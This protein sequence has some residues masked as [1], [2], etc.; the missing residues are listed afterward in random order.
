MRKRNR[1]GGSVGHIFADY[2]QLRWHGIWLISDNFTLTD[3][4]GECPF[5]D[6][7]EGYRMNNPEL[8]RLTVIQGAVE[9]VRTVKEAA[10][11]PSERVGDKAV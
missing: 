9:G 3:Y 2:G 1:P 10:G 5:L 8:E 7:M 11:I 6:K 4:R